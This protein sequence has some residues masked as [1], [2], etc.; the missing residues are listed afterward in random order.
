MKLAF[1]L[2][3]H[4]LCQ[5]IYNSVTDRPLKAQLCFMLSKQ[6]IHLEEN[7]QELNEILQNKHSSKYLLK[8]LKDLNLLEPKK[9]LDIYKELIKDKQNEIESSQLNLADSIVNGI[10]NFGSQKESLFSADPSWISKV[11]DSGIMTA[12]STLGFVYY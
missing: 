7:D 1:K 11:K 9:M 10:V 12:V 8:I 5:S 4:F 2:E 3:D 6:R